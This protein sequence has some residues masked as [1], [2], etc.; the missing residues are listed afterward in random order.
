[1]ILAVPCIS[2]YNAKGARAWEVTQRSEL[3]YQRWLRSTLWVVWF[4]VR[5]WWVVW[6]A[7][8]VKWFDRKDGFIE[9]GIDIVHDLYMWSGIKARIHV[10]NWP[11]VLRMVLRT[12]SSTSMRVKLGCRDR[13]YNVFRKNTGID[14]WRGHDVEPHRG[15]ARSVCA[16]T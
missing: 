15:H 8:G 14:Q 6:V 13:N 9:H 2:W 5:G 16:R 1:M 10:K 4:I 3:R 12:R 11:M 7:W